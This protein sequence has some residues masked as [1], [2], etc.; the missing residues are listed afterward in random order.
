MNL[1]C[2]TRVSAVRSI[3]QRWLTVTI[4]NKKP[5]VKFQQC[6]NNFVTIRN[7]SCNSLDTHRDQS[8]FSKDITKCRTVLSRSLCTPLIGTAE[9]D[10]VK[11]H[12]RRKVVFDRFNDHFRDKSNLSSSEWEVI[13]AAGVETG[14]TTERCDVRIM[15]ACLGF[16]NYKLATNYLS[17]MQQLQRT[18]NTAL[19]GIY[20]EL[21]TNNYQECGEE[22]LLALY[23]QLCTRLPV[24]DLT[25][26]QRAVSALCCTSQWQRSFQYLTF[27]KR[28]GSK[29][30]AKNLSEIM[31]VAFGASETETG[32]RY[33]DIFCEQQY[34]DYI[35]NICLS[36]LDYCKTLDK[37]KQ[38]AAVVELLQ[39]LH[40]LRVFPDRSTA[41]LLHHLLTGLNWNVARTSIRRGVCEKCGEKLQFAS[42]SEQKFDDLRETFLELVLKNG[43]I[44]RGSDPTEWRN[45]N[46]LLEDCGPFTHVCDALNISYNNGRKEISLIKKVIQ[47]IIRLH[48]DANILLVC[49]QH[50]KKLIT[51]MRLP[52]RTYYVANVSQDD[53]YTLYAALH[54]GLAV[55]VVTSD[56]LR[57][58]MFRMRSAEMRRTFRLWRQHCQ[59]FVKRGQLQAPAACTTMSQQSQDGKSWHV[60][61]DDGSIEFSHELPQSWL[62]ARQQSVRRR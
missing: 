44:Y 50:Q 7:I 34:S 52:V 36:Y 46:N 10:P 40:E 5:R 24:F 26:S 30:S 17:H 23:D 28:I 53:S 16:S 11:D 2:I 60:P 41:R 33:F 31:K 1:Q 57:D 42:I 18:P 39:K 13:L 6:Y 29:I 25:M 14:L 27:I 35:N 58:H 56:L 47:H 43:D 15:K 20:M 55:K 19:L 59:L 51:S 54:S 45:F 38:E 48:P 4:V 3:S 9:E 49:R 8:L 22:K 21:C 37:S 61:Y 32:W 12:V 62:C